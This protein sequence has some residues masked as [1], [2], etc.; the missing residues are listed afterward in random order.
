MD[1]K[2][3]KL[4]L[5]LIDVNNFKMVNDNYGHETGDNVL[6]H[7]SN[8]LLVNTSKSDIVARYAGD[9]FI[10]ISPFTDEKGKDIIIKQINE[11][12]RGLS[13]KLNIDISV[14][15]GTSVYPNDAKTLDSLLNIADH[16]MYKKKNVFKEESHEFKRGV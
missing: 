1:K 5:F 7:L 16:S 2:K 8:L 3:E 9:E 15:I 11:E 14:S 10:I 13:E 4:I 12:L 6:K